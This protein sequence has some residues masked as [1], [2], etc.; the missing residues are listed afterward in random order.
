MKRSFTTGVRWSLDHIARKSWLRRA[1]PA[2]A[3]LVT[4]D[5]LIGAWQS[6]HDFRAADV[7][8]AQRLDAQA[9]LIT[10]HI[11]DQLQDVSVS[12]AQIGNMVENR[13]LTDAGLTQLALAMRPELG[14][15]LMAVF[16]P[17]G[18]LL[19]GS[20]AGA[21]NQVPGVD[22]LLAR[23]RNE[24]SAL[25]QGLDTWAEQAVFTIAKGHRNRAGELDAVMIEVIDLDQRVLE[26]VDLPPGTVVLLRD[27]TNR[28][29]ARYPSATSLPIG[30]K[31]NDSTATAGPTPT[32]R[33]M[34]SPLDGRQHLVATR[35]IPLGSA[36]S[37]WIVDVSYAVSDFR[38]NVRH[39]LYLNLAS[40]GM[41]LVMLASAVLLVR[42]EHDLHDQMR[43]FA[44]Q[45][46]TIVENMPTPVA[47]IESDTDKVLLANEAML[48]VFGAVAGAGQPFARL[49]VEPSGWAATQA[50]NHDESVA[51]LTRDG[52]RH[53]LLHS[54]RLDLGGN[55][56]E[57]GALLVTL[58]DVSHQHQQ[59]RQ[60][61]T[62][63]DVDA[64]TG[65]ANRR[66][67]ARSAE[68]AVARAQ[69]QHSPL[70]LLALDLDYFKRVNDTYGHAAGD[71]VLAVMARVLE[72]ALRE[73]DLAARLGGEEF[74]AILPDTTVEQA[75]TVAERIRA[76][77]Q[78]T[79]IIL[80]AGQTISQ[81]VSIGIASYHDA[82]D[83]LVAA[84]ERA[85]AALYAA[86]SAGRN[87]V[88][89]HLSDTSGSTETRPPAQSGSERPAPTTGKGGR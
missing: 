68:Q 53:M 42:R 54:A 36:A 45:V 88:H 20:R 2:L 60:L 86:K 24:P 33:Y 82:E 30:Q 87:R 3:L 52:P 70:S 7:L 16:A 71:L 5:I 17:D 78:S 14:E 23:V 13:T 31:L 15:G 4:L 43:R 74:A 59:L 63:A 50:A 79:P 64:L 83:D 6:W 72:G 48:A 77:I 1:L 67:F 28:V 49:F 58:V 26:G 65:L 21:G 22:S 57:S 32:T 56:R 84:H 19:A 29:I 46:S 40:A 47:V 51:M 39:S 8:A 73:N 81:T 80:E 89:V 85:D 69:A 12:M 41:V 76:S 9:S 10:I 35:R 25:V 55:A 66:C 27:G 75:R 62:E 37:D 18:R 34:R 38:A 11:Q 61:R 44:S